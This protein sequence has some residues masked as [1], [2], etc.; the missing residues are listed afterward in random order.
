[1]IFITGD[2]HGMQD[3]IKIKQAYEN[4]ILSERDYIIIAGDFGGIWDKATLFLNL[5]FYAR[6]KCTI[7][8]VDGNHE[9]FDELNNFPIETWKGGKVH[10][11]SMNLIHLI[12]GEV[13]D[14]EGKSI[15]TIGGAES[16]DK[17]YRIP[18]ISWWEEE[19][20]SMEDIESALRNLQSRNYKVDYIVTHTCAAEHIN[21]CMIARR[22]DHYSQ[23]SEKLLNTINQIC[24]YKKWFFGHWHIDM[25]I[26]KKVRA[27][28]ND[29]IML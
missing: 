14:I 8:F 29:I 25:E 5:S 3:I 7:L 23:N 10:R 4:N 22:P 19:S 12:R 26:S 2:T 9:N 20:I 16:T 15:L 24:N 27:I 6:L 21:K 1:M 18:H 28:Y 17:M 11:I 13:Y